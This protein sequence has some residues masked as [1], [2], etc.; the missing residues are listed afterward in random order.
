VTLR[1]PG[2]HIVPDALAAAAVGVAL[3]IDVVAIA[4]ALAAAKGPEWRMQVLDA[5]G[6]WVVVNDAYNSN[7][8]SAAAAL[9]TLVSMGRGRRTW[10]VLGHMAELGEEEEKEHDRIGRLA[11]R[12]GVSRLV[13]VGEATRPMYE[14]ARRE[15]MAPEDAALVATASDATAL[16]R[17]ALEPGDVVLVKAS[18]AAGLETVAIALAGEAGA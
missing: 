8:A 14:A 9:K 18:R 5:P 3:G 1:L 2:E 10:A 15:G 12:L 11:V 17:G 16:V 7:P 4:G 6:G 13:A